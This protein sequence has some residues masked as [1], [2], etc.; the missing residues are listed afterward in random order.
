MAPAVGAGLNLALVCDIR[1]AGASAW[2]DCRFPAIGRWGR[3]LVRGT[4]RRS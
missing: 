4:R 2:F 1:V 3:R